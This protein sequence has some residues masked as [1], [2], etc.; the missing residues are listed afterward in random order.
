[1]PSGFSIWRI[2]NAAGSFY[3]HDSLNRPSEIN[4]LDLHHIILGVHSADHSWSNTSTPNAVTEYCPSRKEENEN[5]T[6]S[7]GWDVLRSYSKPYGCYM[8]TPHF[9]RIWS[10]RGTDHNKPLSIW[11][12]LTRPGF[13]VLGDCIVEGL[14]FFF[15]FNS[16]FSCSILHCF[17]NYFVSSFSG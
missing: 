14:E 3:A 13:S 11:R 9:E 16:Y 2:D 6:N 12:P 15:L 17:P 5:S 8:S 4:S 1:M 10:D 7:S